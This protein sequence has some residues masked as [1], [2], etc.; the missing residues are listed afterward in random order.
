M[1]SGSGERSTDP[2]IS[3]LSSE[4]PSAIRAGTAI[5]KWYPAGKL[6]KRS[7][8]PIPVSAS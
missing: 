8:V 6:M 4:A 1:S 2:M 3:S 7:S 5:E